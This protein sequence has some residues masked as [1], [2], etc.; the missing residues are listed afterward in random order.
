MIGAGRPAHE[1]HPILSI[2]GGT[3]LDLRDATFEGH[4]AS[5]SALALFGSVEI[6]VPEDV[7]VYT[8]G[9]T[10][11]GSRNVLGQEEGGLLAMG[12]RE[13]PN[14]RAATRRLNL[15]AL[16]IFGSIEVKR[17]KPHLQ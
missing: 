7:G 15:T 12:D 8:E 1:F 14:Y 9:L 10:V 16:S 4:F 2:F 5:L 6:I 13:S 17:A 11:F 3:K